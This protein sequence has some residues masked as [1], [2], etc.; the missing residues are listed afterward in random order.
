MKESNLENLK[1]V[2]KL[3]SDMEKLRK[4]NNAL[5][6]MSIKTERPLRGRIAFSEIYGTEYSLKDIEALIG[7]EK[8][9][10]IFEI[11]RDNL[12]VAIIL[13]LEDSKS[14]LS[15]YEITKPSKSSNG[16]K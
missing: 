1:K 11:F 16:N 10:Q 5:N 4:G 6:T 12:K 8:F 14:E 3:V 15:G 7:S 13:E 2:N 9:D